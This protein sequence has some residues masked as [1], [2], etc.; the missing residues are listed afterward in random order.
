MPIS[1]DPLLLDTSAALASLNP[2]NPHHEAVLSRSRGHGLGLAG[3]AA[4]EAYSALTRMP[5]P[6]RLASGQ[7]Q[8]LLAERFP[9]S[10]F[11][12]PERARGLLAT[13]ADLD[14]VGGAVYDA[15]VAAAAV[16]H[17]LLLLSCDRRAT[18]TYQALG[19]SFE[20]L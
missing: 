2:S 8:R 5:P 19:V 16:E 13:F 18:G 9:H 11:I 17:D 3:H 4:F 1:A 12:S 14:L 6:L 20:I 7:A 15:L 10:R